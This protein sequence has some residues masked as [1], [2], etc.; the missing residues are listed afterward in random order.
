MADRLDHVKTAPNTG[1][2]NRLGQCFRP[3]PGA[4]QNGDAA[5]ALVGRSTAERIDDVVDTPVRPHPPSRPRA[6]R[7]DGTVDDPSPVEDG[8]V[9]R[10][11]LHIDDP[12]VIGRQTS[13]PDVAADVHEH[14]RGASLEEMIDDE[15]A[16]ETLADA[17]E[18]DPHTKRNATVQRSLSISIPSQPGV[19]RLMA[20]AASPA[21]SPGRQLAT[22][23]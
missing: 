19:R 11:V 8:P 18:V 21:R 9:T 12:R 20:D 2:Q 6:A 17:S 23:E 13:D 10:R 14:A 7:R 5:Q 3:P 4:G 15:I 16:G 22:G 1:R